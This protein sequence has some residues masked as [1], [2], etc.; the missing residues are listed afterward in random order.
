M[1]VHPNPPFW[2]GILLPW[3]SILRAKTG[4]SSVGSR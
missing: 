2:R 3:V 4:V 1:T